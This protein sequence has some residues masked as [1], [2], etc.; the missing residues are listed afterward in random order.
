MTKSICNTKIEERGGGGGVGLGGR[1]LASLS[2]H[3]RTITSWVVYFSD[4]LDVSATNS[5]PTIMKEDVF[6]SFRTLSLY[7]DL[8][9]K[10]WQF[11][12]IVEPSLKKYII[13]KKRKK[14][15]CLCVYILFPNINIQIK[16]I[17]CLININRQKKKKRKKQLSFKKFGT[18]KKIRIRMFFRNK[19]VRGKKQSQKCYMTTKWNSHFCFLHPFGFLCMLGILSL[20]LFK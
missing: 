12:L 1:Q 11:L 8:V 13:S 6:V 3:Q 16:T 5:L 2:L 7:V 9:Q 17:Y 4:S 14:K 15:I 18:T 20:L 19:L 10:I